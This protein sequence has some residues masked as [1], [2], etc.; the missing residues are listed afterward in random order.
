VTVE[1]RA[2]EARCRHRERVAALTSFGTN[3]GVRVLFTGPSGTGKTL[4]AGQLS[5]ALGKDAYRVD[6]SAVVNKYIGET[7]KNL[8]RLLSLAEEL[9]VVLLLDEGDALLTRRTAVQSSTDRYA[10]L[11]TNFL[12]QRLETFEGILFVTSNAAE[13]IDGAFQRRMDAIIE[14]R[15]PEVSE[16]RRLWKLHLP[17]G[18]SIAAELVDRIAAQCAL[19]GGQIRNAALHAQLLSFDAGGEV[20]GPLL[21]QSVRREYRK[22][23]TVCPLHFS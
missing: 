3:A 19:S 20:T 4:A 16:R 8:D 1:L 17:A 6:L 10:N 22:L 15:M 2:V 23:G 12:L 14:F 18:S 21:A 13:R 5:R 9:D 11:E 7:E